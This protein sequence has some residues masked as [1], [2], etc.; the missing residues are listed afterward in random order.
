[1]A[2]KKNLNYNPF[3][4]AN[5]RNEK[6]VFKTF[7]TCKYNFPRFFIVTL[8]IIKFQMIRAGPNGCFKFMYGK[9]AGTWQQ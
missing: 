8:R 2:E 5:F 7:L 3:L 9:L 6:K 1:M 4:K